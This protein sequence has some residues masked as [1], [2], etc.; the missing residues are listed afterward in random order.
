ML[1][2]LH[3]VMMLGISAVDA[4]AIANSHVA[5]PSSLI[6][7]TGNT[8]C[9]AAN[10]TTSILLSACGNS[11]AQL[12][13][14]TK[15]DGNNV[16]SVANLQSGTCLFID[17]PITS[18]TPLSLGACSDPDGYSP[19]LNHIQFHTEVALLNTVQLA[20]RQWG[21]LCVDGGDGITARLAECD[22]AHSTQQWAVGM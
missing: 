15:L 11:N 18:G 19:P 21:N 7:N 14:V 6:K 17:Y 1:Q 16:Y 13:N 5:M 2:T 20:S 22:T 12:W 4:A 8:L 9:L 10:S 3:F